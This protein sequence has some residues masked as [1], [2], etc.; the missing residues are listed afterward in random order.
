MCGKQSVF[1]DRQDAGQRLAVQ[2]SHLKDAR[3]VVLAL[4]RGG[5]PVGLEAAKALKAPLELLLVRKLG[6]PGHAEYGIGAV[7]NGAEPQLVLNEEAISLVNPSQEYVDA[8]MRR[9]L[10]R[11]KQLRQKYLSDRKPIPLSGRVVI[12]I[13]DGIATGSTVRAA[14]KGI[15]RSGPSR[16][17][18]AVPVAPREAIE[19]LREEADEVICLS[20]PSNFRAVGLHY[21]N[22]EQTSDADVVA[23][24]DA[25]LRWQAAAN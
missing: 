7:V 8:E 24:L 4:P 14:L 21:E 23:C 6:A 22:F 5:V 18:L 3:P 12:V 19:A 25:A 2:L 16:I 1:R 13:D 11:I 15:R 17:V 20:N 9:Q 10:A